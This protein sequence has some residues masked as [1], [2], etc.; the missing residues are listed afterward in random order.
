[1]KTLSSEIGYYFGDIYDFYR[2]EAIGRA[3]DLYAKMLLDVQ[4]EVTE[5]DMELY[6]EDFELVKKFHPDHTLP[7]MKLSQSSSSNTSESGCYVATSIYGSYD[8]P[9][10][11]TLRRFRDNTL[12]NYYLGRLF[13]K[14]YYAISPTLVKWFGGTSIFKT[15]ITPVLDNFVLY[16]KKKGTSDRP[17]NDKY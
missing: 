10:V 14:T 7:I 1:M 8:C 4:G 17:Y 11:W 12:D 15:I 5:R 9:Q 6:R 16:L 3:V 13:I 2:A